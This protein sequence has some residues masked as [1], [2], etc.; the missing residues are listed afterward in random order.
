MEDPEPVEMTPAE[1][2]VVSQIEA[3]R[4]N[5]TKLEI[6]SFKGTNM[7]GLK[8]A[9]DELGI[10]Y[11]SRG[12]D[13][14]LRNLLVAYYAGQKALHMNLFPDAYGEDA[15]TPEQIE[16]VEDAETETG[17]AGDSESTGDEIPSETATVTS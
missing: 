4:A 7:D 6:P 17:T 15:V 14:T 5:V 1:A 11:P 10:S 9:C 3:L 8:K 13:R 2:S 16:E 12:N